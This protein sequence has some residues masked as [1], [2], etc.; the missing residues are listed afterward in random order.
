MSISVVARGRI[1]GRPSLV[2]S[3]DGDV[4][5]FLLG[6]A[7]VGFQNSSEHAIDGLPVIE[8]TCRSRPFGYR[9]LKGLS[10]DTSVVVIG[11]LHVSLPFDHFD[12][13][14]LV[15]VSIDADTVGVDLAR[16]DPGPAEAVLRA[17]SPWRRLRIAP[18]ALRRGRRRRQHPQ[19][20]QTEETGGPRRRGDI[21]P[22]FC[23]GRHDDRRADGLGNVA[24]PSDAGV[25]HY[26]STVDS[27]RPSM[28]GRTLGKAD[29]IDVKVEA[30]RHDNTPNDWPDLVR[31]EGD[32]C[33]GLS[34][35]INLEAPDARRLGL[36]LVAAADLTER[37]R[38]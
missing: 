21:C 3:D 35:G 33:P 15:L 24:H 17:R 22:S 30:F 37:T 16:D 10:N 25:M 14:D 28:D 5:S 38:N 23:C 6:D 36:A 32:V 7:Q 19:D 2:T 29:A 18:Q 13:R 20:G 8:V 27:W 34:S 12:D 11:A 9:V 26:S 1:V 4:V 31:V